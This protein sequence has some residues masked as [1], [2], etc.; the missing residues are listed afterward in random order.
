MGSKRLPGKPLLDLDGAPMVC[1]VAGVAKASG[2]SRV[3]VAADHDEIASAVRSVGI[4][5]MLTRTDHAT[6][7]DRLA[8]A[9]VRLG[10]L[11]TQIVVNLQADEP[12]MPAQALAQAAMA[13]HAQPLASVSTAVTS[14]DPIEVAN[15]HQVKAVCDKNGM[16]LYFSR[17]AIPFWRD[18]TPQGDA[19]QVILRHLG[20]YAYRAGPLVEF[21]GWGPCGIET[22]EQLEQL[23][24]LYHGHR[25]TS[26]WLE[27]PPPAGVDTP[28][29]LERIRAIYKASL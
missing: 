2:A 19:P 24:W 28:E 13:L 16:A 22:M 27:S 25:I 3:V 6:G 14:I 7:T 1:R 11:P 9:V 4:E 23:R 20:L 18:P 10:A 15:P 21:A 26:F 8:E 5:C 29:D 12:L 17:S